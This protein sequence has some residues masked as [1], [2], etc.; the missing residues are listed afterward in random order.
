MYGSA[1]FV[2]VRLARPLDELALLV[3]IELDLTWR[4]FGRHGLLNLSG[5]TSPLIKLACLLVG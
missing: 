5:L 4:L 1:C 2:T 3:R